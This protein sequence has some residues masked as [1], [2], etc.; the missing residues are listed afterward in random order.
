MLG[1]RYWVPVKGILNHVTDLGRP[2]WLG[3]ELR[4]ANTGIPHRVSLLFIL[5]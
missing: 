4:M 5:R 2:L 3:H 1:I